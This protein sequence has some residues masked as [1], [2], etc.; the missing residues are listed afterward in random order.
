MIFF[1]EQDLAWQHLLV[2]FVLIL[3]S[4]SKENIR[5]FSGIQNM[6]CRVSVG[7]DFAITPTQEML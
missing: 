4:G 2:P 1:R 3:F 6:F 7:G 5:H